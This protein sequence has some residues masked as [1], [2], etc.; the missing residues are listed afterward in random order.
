M[1]H[2]RNAGFYLLFNLPR[3]TRTGILP[4]MFSTCTYTSLPGTTST[5]CILPPTIY[6]L[7]SLP[8]GDRKRM[9]RTKHL[10][11]GI[12]DADA[13]TCPGKPNRACT[14][15][16]NP[17]SPRTSQHFPTPKTSSKPNHDRNID[18]SHQ[19]PTQILHRAM[20]HYGSA[21]LEIVTKGVR[22]C[23]I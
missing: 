6:R 14:Q 10:D 4:C 18:G 7:D 8:L 16:R 3:C 12:N 19:N 20:P 22:R 21:V 5:S 23:G 17:A 11:L 15:I 2:V 1:C 9:V 13:M